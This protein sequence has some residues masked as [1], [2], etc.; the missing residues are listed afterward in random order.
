[1]RVSDVFEI[2]LSGGKKAYGHFVFRD[3]KNRLFIQ[4]FDVITHDIEINT[5]D[6]IQ[7][8]YLF[9][10]V[11]TDPIG[12]VK[13]GMWKKIGKIPV[14]DF[15]YPNFI[16]AIYDYRTGKVQNWFLC[17]PDKDIPLGPILPEEYKSLEYRIIWNPVDIVNRIE[18]G[19]YP[20]PYGEMIK[21]NH[22]QPKNN[23]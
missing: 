7:H 16:G 18:T 9:P 12:A 22:F 6:L 10:P 15:V 20:F 1:M 3:K 13:T 8:D 14:V 4:V 2:P 5:E 11:L 17:E 23:D 19:Q 21:N